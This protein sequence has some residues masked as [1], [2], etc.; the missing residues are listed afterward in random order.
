MNPRIEQFMDRQRV[1]TFC[2]VDEAHQPY[3]FT[4]FYVLDK[5]HHLLIFKSGMATTHAQLLMKNPSI[6]GTIQPEKLNPL[7][8]KGV[9]FRGK[10]IFDDI[11]RQAAKTL[12]HKKYLFASTVPGEIWC[13]QLDSVK[14][15]DNT[16]HFAKK[17]L[18]E[19]GV[20]EHS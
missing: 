12:Y 7:A 16:L 14:M 18:W 17:I 8:I 13:V 2:C 20:E 19:A 11:M 15:T 9:Q 3:C 1:A 10:V 5:E 4:C 6:A